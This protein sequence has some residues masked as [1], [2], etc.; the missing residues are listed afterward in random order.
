MLTNQSPTG[1]TLETPTANKTDQ[2]PA[3]LPESIESQSLTLATESK[4]V[5]GS[6]RTVALF[7]GNKIA[8]QTNSK[9][10]EKELKAL[11]TLYKYHG[12]DY[13]VPVGYKRPG[14]PNSPEITETY[15]IYKRH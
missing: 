1:S 2:P 6:F 7:N 10:S 14:D 3:Y 4:Q 5:P 15:P 9:I 8:V 12:D 11:G 13:T